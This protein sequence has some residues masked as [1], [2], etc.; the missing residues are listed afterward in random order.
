M[1]VYGS[2]LHGCDFE[3]RALQGFLRHAV[4][5]ADCKRSFRGVI[6]GYALRIALFDK[7]V[8]RRR[9]QNIATDGR[10]L[11]RRDGYAG[12]KSGYRKLSVAVG[13][14]LAVIVSDKRAAAVA[15]KESCARN[16]RRRSLDVQANGQ[17]LRRVVIE[18]QILR[19]SALDFDSFRRPVHEIAVRRRK[20]FRAY[21][22]AGREAA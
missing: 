22:N 1:I 5:L 14:K 12:R 7:D 8:L 11:R 19:V 16:R 10:R 13:R 2:S 15:H 18:S 9:V 6:K 4:E 21:R 17:S 20:L 3:L